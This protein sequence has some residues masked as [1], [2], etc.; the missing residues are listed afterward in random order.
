MK[1]ILFITH[2]DMTGGSAKSL[3]SQ[4]EYLKSSRQV[5]PIVITWKNNS[6]TSCLMKKGIQCHAVKYDFTSVWT[7]N[8]LFHIIKRPYYRLFYNCIAYKTLRSKIDF[9]SIS[10]IVS[11]SSVIDFGAYLHQRLQIPHI[12]Y[13]REFGDLDFNIQPYIKNFPHY[14]DEKSD[15]IIAVSKAVAEHWKKRGIRKNIDVIYN[16]VSNTSFSKEKQKR[17]PIINICMC[18]RLCP[19]KGQAL[20]LKSLILL[21]KDILEQIHLDFFGK[22]ESEKKLRVFVKSNALEK[23]VSFK[24]HSENLE[25]ELYNYEIGLMLSNAEGFGRTTAEYMTHA[26]FVIGANTGGTPE[27]LQYGKYGVLIAPNEPKQLAEA[28]TNYCQN[29]NELQKRAL[30][31][32]TYAEREFSI[33][34]NAKRAYLLYKKYMK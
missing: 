8:E 30:E 32:P 22:G 2:D 5:D 24:G 12:W 19:A 14:I 11:N 25:H 21:P 10:L 13:L 16:G 3:L 28:I 20:A 23:N 17:G 15:A 34:K 27:L 26:L 7:R 1:K 6:L 9:S 33:S 31:A 4:I 29:R 18:G